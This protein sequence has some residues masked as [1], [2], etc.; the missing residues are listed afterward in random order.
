MADQIVKALSSNQTTGESR[1]TK[2]FL[3]CELQEGKSDKLGHIVK[4]ILWM[5]RNYA[6]YRTERGVYLHFSDV[7][8]EEADQRSR[9]TDICPELC[10]LR[11]FTSQMRSSFGSRFRSRPRLSKSSL[12]DHNMAQAIMLIMEKKVEPGKKIAEQALKMAVQRATN[13][14]TIRYIRFCL[15][16]WLGFLVAGAIALALISQEEFRRY[17]VAGMVGATGAVLSVATRLQSFQLQPCNQSNMNYWMS[18]VRVGIGALAGQILLLLASTILIEKTKALLP[19]GTLQWEGVAVL[20]I[21][22]GFAE[23]LI[24]NLLG[25]TSEQVEQPVGTPVLAIRSE[26]ARSSS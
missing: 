5:G 26:S 2:P 13:D 21:L 6:I 11:Y 23:R 22:A 9:F 17:V 8:A 15:L 4:D 1:C 19:G 7:P 20:G 24:P 16:C 12:Y 3:L 18:G 10:E 14:N 25:R